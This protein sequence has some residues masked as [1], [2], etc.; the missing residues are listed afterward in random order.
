MPRQGWLA[1]AFTLVA[2]LVVPSIASADNS[3][4]CRSSAVRASLGGTDV[5]EPTVANRGND[6]CAADAAGVPGVQALGAAIQQAQTRDAYATTK[7]NRIK[8]NPA[9][10]SASSE[11]G[12]SH[13]D[14][15]ANPAG[16]WVLSADG[17]TSKATAYCAGSQTLF[18][19]SSNVGTVTLGGQTLDLNGPAEQL[20]DGISGSPLGALVKIKANGEPSIQ[21]NSVTKR[22]LQITVTLGGNTV[23]DA[24]VGESRAGGTCTVPPAPPPCPDTYEYDVA[25][26]TCVR[27]ITVPGTG[28]PRNPCPQGSLEKTDGTCARVEYVPVSGNSAGV[29]VVM[30]STASSNGQGGGIPLTKGDIDQSRLGPCANP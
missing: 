22:A 17:V 10:Q 5:A 18:D 1:A 3:F 6:P 11:A 23:L 9:E 13:V 28:N 12:V 4:S 24:V 8:P 21:G 16:G 30:G 27:T 7:T 19:T 20:F 25:T 15:L 29:T 26:G 2:I 14:A